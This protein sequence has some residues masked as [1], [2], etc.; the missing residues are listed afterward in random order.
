MTARQSRCP[1]IIGAADALSHRGNP[2][3]FTRE[4]AVAWS[5]AD[6]DFPERG[7]LA[8]AAEGS[9]RLLGG[10]PEHDHHRF[11]AVG[12]HETECA[13]K[14][15]PVVQRKEQLVGD[16]PMC[17]RAL[18]CRAASNEL[19]VHGLLLSQVR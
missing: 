5:D 17:F 9:L 12:I 15:G 18:L 4:Q 2:P 19:C 16:D 11:P 1:P 10:V 7:R 3:V 13:G 14:A 6:G 8:I